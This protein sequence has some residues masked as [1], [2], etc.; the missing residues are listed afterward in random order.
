MKRY[1]KS[2]SSLPQEGIF[3]VI[4]DRLI[5]FSDDVSYNNM[6]IDPIDL[7]H[8][9][10]WKKIGEDFKVDGKIVPFDYFPRGRVVISNGKDLKFKAEIY[11]DNCIKSEWWDK[12]LDKFDISSKNCEIVDGGN[13]GFFNSIYKCHNCK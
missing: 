11:I 13:F 3:W 12:I 1:I 2:S 9:E 7:T 6:N 5:Q 8:F 4:N 10:V